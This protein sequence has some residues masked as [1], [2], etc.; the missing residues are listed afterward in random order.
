MHHDHIK[1]RTMRRSVLLLVIGRIPMLTPDLDVRMMMDL[2]TTLRT[3]CPPFCDSRSLQDVAHHSCSQDRSCSQ[4]LRW[5][6]YLHP[7]ETCCSHSD[8]GHLCFRFRHCLL[9]QRYA[10]LLP[11]FLHG[12]CATAWEWRAF[13]G[14][15]HRMVP[16]GTLQSGPFFL[17]SPDSGSFSCLYNIPRSTLHVMP[18]PT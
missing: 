16:Q 9:H 17:R 15:S 6:G 4:C 8:C 2:K 18:V 7:T 14:Y 1:T 5:S 12:F 10:L 13:T 11:Q 3:L